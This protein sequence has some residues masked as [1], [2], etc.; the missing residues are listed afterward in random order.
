MGETNFGFLIRDF[1]FECALAF[2]SNE[3]PPANVLIP[4]KALLPILG[5]SLILS[6]ASPAGPCRK[7]VRDASGRIVQTIDNHQT[8][9]TTR[10]VIRNASGRIIGTS[11]NRTSSGGT[12]RTTYRDASGRITG[13]ASSHGAGGKSSRTTYRD[14]S[15]RMTG[16]A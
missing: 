13:S 10:S 11:T 4:M 3:F 16:S 5:L 7:T 8:G 14:A 9:S 1:E 2:D 6:A 15:G 12:T